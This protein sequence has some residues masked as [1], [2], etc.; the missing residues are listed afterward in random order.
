MCTLSRQSSTPDAQLGAAG[1]G[2]NKRTHAPAVPHLT[3]THHP[4]MAAGAAGSSVQL[5]LTHRPPAH[6][7]AVTVSP[8][9]NLTHGEVNTSGVWQGWALGLV[10]THTCTH[11]LSGVSEAR[12]TGTTKGKQTRGAF[13][14][15]IRM[16][17]REAEAGG[18]EGDFPARGQPVSALPVYVCWRLQFGPVLCRAPHIL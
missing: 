13:L 18:E 5:K 4:Q 2:S 6:R 11:T 8:E 14:N 9:R 17:R 3:A 10:H 7:T 1:S 16:C 12:A 15:H